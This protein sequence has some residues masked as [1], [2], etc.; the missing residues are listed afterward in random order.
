MRIIYWRRRAVTL[1]DGFLLPRLCD[2]EFHTRLP[3]YMY[4]LCG[5]VIAFM[6]CAAVLRNDLCDERFAVV[7]E[8]IT[9]EHVSASTSLRLSRYL[10]SAKWVPTREVLIVLLYKLYLPK[11]K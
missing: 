9:W 1:D 7:C 6:V 2:C 11:N 4:M 8:F 5:I 3:G 10:F